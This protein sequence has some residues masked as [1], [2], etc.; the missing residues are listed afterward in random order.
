MVFIPIISHLYVFNVLLL[1]VF[2]YNT[3][4]TPLCSRMNGSSAVNDKDQIY[5]PDNGNDIRRIEINGTIIACNSDGTIISATSANESHT[6]G[7]DG[8]QLKKRF[9]HGKSDTGLPLFILV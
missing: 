2:V 9:E 5:F 3:R 1:G 4:S 7:T 8:N 6:V